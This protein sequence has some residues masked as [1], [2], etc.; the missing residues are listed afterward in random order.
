MKPA[1]TPSPDP[2]GP[3]KNTKLVV[4]PFYR[5][6]RSPSP[7]QDSGNHYYQQALPADFD[8]P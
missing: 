7:L 6:N 2:P 1:R 5:H 3:V 8:A 4:N